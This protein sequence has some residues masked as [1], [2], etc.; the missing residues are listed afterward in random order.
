[1]DWR[2]A[3]VV[4]SE[5][6]P[7]S[8][9]TA[10][11]RSG[12]SDRTAPGHGGPPPRQSRVW[13]VGPLWQSLK[14]GYH[15]VVGGL[16][17]TLFVAHGL[18]LSYRA[19]RF[20]A[21]NHTSTVL[22]TDCTS[23]YVGP[24]DPGDDFFSFEIATDKLPYPITRM[25]QVR[26]DWNPLRPPQP[27]T[28]WCAMRGRAIS[29]HHSDRLRL[30]VP[31]VGGGWGPLRQ[32]V[33]FMQVLRAEAAGATFLIPLFA[34]AVVA[35]LAVAGLVYSIYLLSTLE[36]RVKRGDG[37]SRLDFALRKTNRWIS[38]FGNG[39]LA[40]GILFCLGL[41][42]L[43]GLLLVDEGN[44]IETGFAALAGL[45]L[46]S[47]GPAGVF[48]GVHLLRTTRVQALHLARNVVFLAVLGVLLHKVWL[49]YG[50]IEDTTFHTI[51]DLLS[52]I[53]LHGGG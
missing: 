21:D 33:L 5:T 23:T 15:F 49:A 41:A 17:V 13:R 53:L 3:P 43:K 7:T 4:S 8:A 46:V 51:G 45:A 52:D 20:I 2:L 25:E 1:V 34:L 14:V 6:A 40:A 32:P 44:S 22:V 10:R 11:S 16:L 36:F 31:D 12:P 28:D 26:F 42:L 35:G 39:S 38:M 50:R 19:L 9:E 48:H 37:E 24:A 30:A 47:V 27:D 29:V 18:G